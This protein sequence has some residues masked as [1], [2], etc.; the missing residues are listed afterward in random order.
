[1]GLF[2]RLGQAIRSSVN[3][4]VQENEDPESLLDQAVADMQADLIHVRQAVAQAIATQ[5]R[6]ERQCNQAQTLAQEWYN[7]AHLALQKGD[8]YNARE[9]LERRQSYL[10]TVKQLESHLQQQQ[11]VVSQL[12]DNMRFL[13]GKIA[14]ARIR[15][16]MYIAR[17]RSAEASQRIQELISQVN[18]SGLGTFAQVEDKVLELE[19]Q[20]A[21]IAE[22]NATLESQTP[23]ARFAALETGEH[24]VEAELAAMKQRLRNSPPAG[25]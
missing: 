9:A 11:G 4:W 3:S 6:T 23:E 8:E 24:A 13:E 15:R 18:P 12:K 2:Q 25:Q 7:R 10:S 19:A 16:D 21:A 14:D 17:I 5:K 1:M 22:L 20:S